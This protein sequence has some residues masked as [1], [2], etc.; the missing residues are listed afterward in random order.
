MITGNES[1]L[2]SILSE[3]NT[4]IKENRSMEKKTIMLEPK[5][6]PKFIKV[7]QILFG[8]VCSGIAIFWVIF[9]L[10]SSDVDKTGWITII[11]LAGFGLYEIFAGSG[12]TK[13]YITTGAQ[14]IVLKQN[15]VLPAVTIKAADISNIELLLLSIMFHKKNGQKLTLRFGINYPEVIEQVKQEVIDFAARNNITVLSDAD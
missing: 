13:K 4:D 8:I 7:L 5:E 11:F 3:K 2:F 10:S 9:N 15:A 6:N 14:M 1:L 12:K